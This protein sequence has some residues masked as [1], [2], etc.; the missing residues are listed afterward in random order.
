MGNDYH[1][2]SKGQ[3]P[4]FAAEQFTA[5]QWEAVAMHLLKQAEEAMAR[6]LALRMQEDD[7]EQPESDFPA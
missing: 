5:D 7:P 1:R 4:S 2:E 3:E 6:A